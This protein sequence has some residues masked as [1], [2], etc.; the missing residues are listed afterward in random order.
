MSNRLSQEQMRIVDTWGQGMA[1][2]AGAGSGKTTTLVAKCA[3]LLKRKPEA[4]FA[5]VSFTEKSAR[6]LKTKLTERLTA[7]SGGAP[8]TVMAGHWVNTIH[9]LCASIIK[10]YPRESG[11][12]GEESMLSEAE[13]QLLWEK[14]TEGLWFEELPDE[15]YQA[16]ELML[17]RESKAALSDLLKR[18]RNLNSFGVLNYL[19]SE[20]SDKDS[21]AL[22]RVGAYVL[23]RYDRL[24]KRRGAVDF[25][26]LELGADRALENPDVCADYQRRFELVMVDEFQ[27]TN[28]IQAKIIWRIVRPGATNLCIV[29]DPKQSIYRFR[30]ADVTVFEECCAKL[31]VRIS[32]TANFRSRPGV[33]EFTN[34][35]CQPAFEASAMDYESL[36]AKREVGEHEAVIQLN[37]TS[38]QELGHWVKSE[39]DRGIPLSDMALLLSKIRGNEKWLQG[40]TQAGIPI[41]VES[42]GLFWDDPRVREL[43]AFLKWW[44]NPG[45]EFS[46]AVFLRAPWVGVSDSTLDEWRKKDPSFRKVFFESEH[47]VALALKPFLDHQESV[48]PGELLMALLIDQKIEDEIGVPLLGLWHRVEEF[49][50]MRLDFHAVIAEL[51]LAM[52]ETRREKTVPPPR[53]AGQLVVLT[54]HG[55][56]GLEF[57]HVILVDLPEKADKTPNAPLLFWDRNRGAHLG[58]R[59]S[60]GERD[61]KDPLEIQWREDEKKKELAE[62]K[63]LFYV[64]LTRAE[65]RLILVL[66]QTPDFE[67]KL[68]G[69]LDKDFWR[70]WLQLSQVRIPVIEAKDFKSVGQAKKLKD[71]DAEKLKEPEAE[72]VL[73]IAKRPRHSVTEWT[74]LSRCPRAYEWK[75]IRP[76]LV[77][78]KKAHSESHDV[79][80]VG[81]PQVERGLAANELGTR[82]HKAL[83]TGDQEDLFAL[84]TEVGAARFQA[85]PVIAWMAADAESRSSNERW[86]EIAFEVPFQGEAIVGSMDRLEKKGD[87]Y[88]IVDFKVTTKAKS[89]EELL[90]SYQSQIELYALAL[91]ILEPA[92]RGHTDACLVNFSPG[93][94]Q[95]VRVPIDHEQT[96]QLAAKTSQLAQK[97]IQGAA[98]VPQVGKLCRVCEFRGICPEGQ[99]H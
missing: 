21:H 81:I 55:A 14:A 73:P 22:A 48:R 27:D 72:K 99:R 18:L 83:E 88:S 34:Q 64:A 92:A 56:K 94:V 8:D 71:L 98:G 96:L 24:K 11:F 12:D 41:A 28:P 52:E 10:E 85:A 54:I 9:G 20:T 69:A 42:G 30:D 15:V 1:V 60:D 67:I 39:V 84:E 51:T 75:F 50:S 35:V 97:I 68:E 37:T 17:E 40:L 90:D 65:E 77:P 63:R 82:V 36:V 91:G 4:R 3:E 23:E 58:K 47:P 61:K 57:P 86:S 74:T 33:I 6:D 53:G 49:S 80:A 5:A 2:L 13:S 70:G 95:V 45:N 93:N 78:E 25:N 89:E 79:P 29:G 44:D 7:D 31:P 26:D 66:H 62:S 76:V 43:T 16:L 87:Q 32:L 38:P 19:Q 59:D 46:G